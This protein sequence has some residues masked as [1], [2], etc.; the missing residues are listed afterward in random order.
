MGSISRFVGSDNLP[1]FGDP[2]LL[3]REL[4]QHNPSFKTRDTGK[5][6]D[7]NH[8]LTKLLHFSKWLR[9]LSR[10]DLSYFMAHRQREMWRNPANAMDQQTRNVH[11]QLLAWQSA[12]VEDGS[13]P[14]RAPPV[15]SNL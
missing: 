8:A 9:D 2:V 15:E 4:L 14:P 13:A 10:R 5:G 7:L 11:K 3:F 12:T 6:W 1:P